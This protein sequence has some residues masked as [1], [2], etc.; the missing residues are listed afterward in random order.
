MKGHVKSIPGNKG[1]GFIRASN[2][3]E[4]FFHESDFNGH[5]RDLVTDFNGN[6]SPVEVT[7]EPTDTPKGLRAAKVKRLDYPNEGEQQ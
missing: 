1:F 5:W 4:Y 7:F 3:A 6:D 2:G